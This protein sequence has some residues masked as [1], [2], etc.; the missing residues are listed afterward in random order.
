MRKE[1]Q[2]KKERQNVMKAELKFFFFL[3]VLVSRLEVRGRAESR[4]LSGQTF[5]FIQCKKKNHEDISMEIMISSKKT[6]KQKTQFK[7]VY[8]VLKLDIFVH[9]NTQYSFTAVVFYTTLSF[10]WQ[11]GLK[12]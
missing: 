6:K 11:T 9:Q 8:E 4:R 2:N 1:H 5:L 3:S 12:A 10:V 7:N